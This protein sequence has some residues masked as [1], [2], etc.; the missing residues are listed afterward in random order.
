MLKEALQPSGVGVSNFSYLYVVPFFGHVL[1]N[2]LIAIR[3]RYRHGLG[4]LLF[5]AWV[6]TRSQQLFCRFALLSGVPQADSGV[7]PKAQGLLLTA[8]P[9]SHLPELG[10]GR[11]YQQVEPPTVGDFPLDSIWFCVPDVGIVQGHLVYL[12]LF[13]PLFYQQIAWVSISLFILCQCVIKSISSQ[14][15]DFILLNTTI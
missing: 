11:I 8:E 13:Y 15:I 10:A 2:V 6:Y 4:L 5:F 1:K 3:F 12:L 9:V 7:L 14:Y